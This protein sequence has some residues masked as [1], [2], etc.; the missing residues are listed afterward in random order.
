MFPYTTHSVGAHTAQLYPSSDSHP[1]L[2]NYGRANPTQ[3][4]MH[5]PRLGVLLTRF[6]LESTFIRTRSIKA[7][8]TVLYAAKN[9]PN[10]KPNTR[11]PFVWRPLLLTQSG[12]ILS[13]IRANIIA[14]FRRQKR[15][16]RTS[17][18]SLGARIPIHLSSP[19]RRQSLL[20]E[21]LSHF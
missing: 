16:A 12:C 7:I 21:K 4:R 18:I 8:S 9:A 3:C 6:V 1:Q 2:S 13:I 19:P 10:R 17:H 15:C 5:C 11:G 20:M 14:A